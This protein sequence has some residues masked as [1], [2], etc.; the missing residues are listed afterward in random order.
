MQPQ[1]N[2]IKPRALIR[3]GFSDGEIK[4]YGT[5][6]RLTS[7]PNLCN[8]KPLQDQWPEFVLY[9]LTYPNRRVGMVTFKDRKKT[10]R[11]RLRALPPVHTARGS[12]RSAQVHHGH[13]FGQPGC[14]RPT[15]RP[16]ARRD[17]RPRRPPCLSA[18]NAHLE[19][20]QNDQGAMAKRP[21]R[22]SRSSRRGDVRRDDRAGWHQPTRW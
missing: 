18:A 11:R 15:A 4:T 7:A 16:A 8:E 6:S 9:V 12:S 20:T 3:L 14:Q 19:Q 2:W 1:D 13:A 5:N 10:Q 21:N 17:D 22:G